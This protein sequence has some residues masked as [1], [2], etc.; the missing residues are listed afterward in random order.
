[1]R[2]DIIVPD[3]ILSVKMQK[4]LEMFQTSKETSKTKILLVVY[5]ELLNYLKL[6]G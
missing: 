4:V 1:M 2:Q 3:T 6:E 5:L